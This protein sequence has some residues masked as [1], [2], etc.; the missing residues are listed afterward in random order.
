[1]IIIDYCIRQRCS[2]K[3]IIGI[4]GS[5]VG[6]SDKTDYDITSVGK[7]SLNILDLGRK[8]H[9]G[10]SIDVKNVQKRKKG[11]WK[12]KKSI[13]CKQVDQLSQRDR[14]AGWVSYGQKW[15]TGTGRQY[16]RIFTYLLTYLLIIW[17]IF[18]CSSRVFD[19]DIMSQLVKPL[20]SISYVIMSYHSRPFVVKICRK[21]RVSYPHHAWLITPATATAAG[22]AIANI[23]PGRFSP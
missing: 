22:S 13:I 9:E 11:H 23:P 10:W 18:S 3:I 15:K 4:V 12:R 8:W 7:G 17:V 2:D 21:K 6:D 14:I 19:S 1:M 16:L 5:S 20:Y